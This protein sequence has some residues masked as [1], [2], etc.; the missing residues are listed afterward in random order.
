QGNVGILPAWL[1][2]THVRLIPVSQKYLD[3]CSQFSGKLE[4]QGIRVD[5]DDREE[6]VGKRIREAEKEWVPYIIVMG[7]KEISN[8]NSLNV[9][10]RG[11][12]EVVMSMD[13]VIHEISLNLK[14]KPNL[15]L[16]L[17]K[18][19]SKRPSFEMTTSE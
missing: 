6:S 11:K 17:P 16:P 4:Q 15:P 1:S 9:R 3:D 19:M 13:E 5:I 12:G 10:K 18:M 2:P 7:E 8:P 14:G